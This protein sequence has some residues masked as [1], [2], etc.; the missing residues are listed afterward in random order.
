[1]SK[2][3]EMKGRQEGEAG[4]WTWSDQAPHSACLLLS[5]GVCTC[6][7]GTMSEVRKALRTARD[8]LQK[9]EYDEALTVLK[10]ILREDKNCYEAYV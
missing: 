7:D 2:Q 8:H 9:K 10:G 6:A 5:A 4:S 3:K 1:M